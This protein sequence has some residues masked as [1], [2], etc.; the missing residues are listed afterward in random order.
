MTKKKLLILFCLFLTGCDI[1]GPFRH[2]NIHDPFSPYYI[3]YAVEQVKATVAANRVIRVQWN[4]KNANSVKFMIERREIPG[5]DSYYSGDYHLIAEIP[6]SGNTVNYIDSL[7]IKR[8]DSY[9]YRITV[10]KGEHYSGYAFSNKI[11]YNPKNPGELGVT[12]LSKSSLRFYWKSEN[13][14]P[15][16]YWIAY[17]LLDGNIT[18]PYHILKV[19]YQDTSIVIT[20]L[21]NTK[22]YVLAVSVYDN[23]SKDF[24]STMPVFYNMGWKY[25]QGWIYGEHGK[26]PIKYV[27]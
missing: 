2:R 10:R 16:S 11:H 23:A 21:D 24:N 14:Y 4:T 8:Y 19:N 20:G 18:N 12:S 27:R 9:Q 17:M 15:T 7:N 25:D 5:Y 3:P 26:D 6:D 22:S 1:Q 13:N